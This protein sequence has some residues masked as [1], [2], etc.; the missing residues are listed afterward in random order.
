MTIK[1]LADHIVKHFGK[2]PYHYGDDFTVS[3][4]TN[5]CLFG[6]YEKGKLKW[7]G[8]AGGGYK[9]RELLK[10]EE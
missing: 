1:D 8:H 3:Y 4:R 10:E 9:E 5:I 6:P 2:T 7:K